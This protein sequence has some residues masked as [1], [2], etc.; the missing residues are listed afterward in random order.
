MTEIHEMQSVEGC[1][2]KYRISGKKEV[3][4]ERTYDAAP[5]TVF[6]AFTDKA[7]VDSWWGSSGSKLEIHEMDVKPGGKWMFIET[8]ARGKKSTFHGEYKEI[9][10]PNRI[11][12]T[13]CY[14]K[15]A[16]SKLFAIEETYE[17]QAI[18]K[19][20]LLRLTS[21]YR[22]G[23]AMKGMLSVGMEEPGKFT[24]GTRHQ[25]RLDRLEKIV[26]N[27]VA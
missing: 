9:E 1:K 14:G 6:A 12:M 15:G 10:E 17:F 3:T 20:T 4:F 26:E 22:M 7:R 18:G 23:F 8:D 11:V 13:L 27:E 16:A 5:A 25:W 24:D 19:Q 21:R 2:T